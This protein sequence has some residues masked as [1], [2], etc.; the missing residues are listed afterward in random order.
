MSSN[1]LFP[2]E[3]V[4][5]CHSLS[6]NSTKKVLDKVRGEFVQGPSK[7]LLSLWHLPMEWPPPIKL[8]FF[9][10]KKLKFVKFIFTLPSLY[11]KNPFSRI[12]LW[13]EKHLYWHLVIFRLGGILFRWLNHFFLQGNRV[14]V[15]KNKMSFWEREKIPPIS[16]IATYEANIQRSA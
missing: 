13:H 8:Y 5:G 9:F 11:L 14:W 4:L 12:H 2:V 15:L 16:S 10:V 6:S 7:P 3:T 1:Y